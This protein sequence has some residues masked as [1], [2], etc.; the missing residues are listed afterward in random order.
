MS[1]AD[2]H[3]IIQRAYNHKGKQLLFG[4]VLLCARHFAYII[5][6]NYRR[7]KSYELGIVM[8]LIKTLNCQYCKYFAEDQAAGN[9]RTRQMPPA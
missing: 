3:L 4:E 6:F 7:K 2:S 5:S 9:L 8:T 1:V